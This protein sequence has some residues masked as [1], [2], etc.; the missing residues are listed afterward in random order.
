M[1]QGAGRL[2][3]RAAVRGSVAQ[4]LAS[5]PGV[6]IALFAERPQTFTCVITLCHQTVIYP[7]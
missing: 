5:G 6:A 4:V 2:C 1:M 3:R 7:R